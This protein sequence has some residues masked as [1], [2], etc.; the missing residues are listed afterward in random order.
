VGRLNAIVRSTGGR[1][2]LTKDG[3]ST[4][5]DF[6]AME[7]R[8]EQFWAIK[9]KWDPQGRIRSAQSERLMSRFMRA[10]ETG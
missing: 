1:I 2:Y 6:Q 8:L 9:N 7:P 5:E 3:L 10:P 4:A